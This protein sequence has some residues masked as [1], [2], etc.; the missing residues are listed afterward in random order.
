MSTV[1]IKFL[2]IKI[3][4]LSPEQC[5]TILYVRMFFKIKSPKIKI[6]VLIPEQCDAMFH[7]IPSSDKLYALYKLHRNIGAKKKTQQHDCKN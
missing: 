7:I 1:K 6:A 3:A 4:I 2:M 5:D